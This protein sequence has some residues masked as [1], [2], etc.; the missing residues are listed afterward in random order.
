MGAW[1]AI[2]M[3][4]FGALFAALTLAF[5]LHWRGI[6]LGLPYLAFVAIALAALLALRL[7]GEG[8]APSKQAEKV[9]MWSSIAEGIGLF[10][11]AQTTI[12]LGHR[13]MLLPAM[14]LVVGLHFL[15]MARA[16]P[17]RPFYG[18]GFALL[19]ASAAGFAIGGTTGAELA[20]FAGAIALWTA[21]LLAIGRERQA[22]AAGGVAT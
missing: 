22:R 16:I 3:S 17:F 21:S 14:A 18:L 1:G 13:E 12:S 7:P 9:I 10:V 8:I 20:G 15:P 11:A 19:A 4:F 6:M 2:I 5:E